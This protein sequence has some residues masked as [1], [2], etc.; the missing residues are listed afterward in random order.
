MP[1]SQLAAWWFKGQSE[2]FRPPLPPFISYSI[3]TLFVG[4]LVRSRRSPNR[5]F[6]PSIP[7]IGARLLGPTGGPSLGCERPSSCPMLPDMH[8]RWIIAAWAH[9]HM[10][11]DQSQGRSNAS[12]DRPLPDPHSPLGCLPAPF[13]V[14]VAGGGQPCL[15]R[16]EREPGSA[17]E[18]SLH[19]SSTPT[20]FRDKRPDYAALPRLGA[21]HARLGP[22]AHV[23]AKPRLDM[24]RPA[25][26]LEPF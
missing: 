2:A 23:W 15:D 24:G 22:P 11:P 19:L 16:P 25:N 4:T 17:T 18:H 8:R 10:N 14:V 6:T 7:A 1:L 5:P 9:G 13:H 26:Y 3:E 20:G 21:P 12:L